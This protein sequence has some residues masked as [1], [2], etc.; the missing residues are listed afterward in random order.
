V[1]QLGGG[2][3]DHRPRRPTG[4]Q[5]QAEPTAGGGE[6]PGAGPFGQQV[7]EPGVL[8]GDVVDVPGDPAVGQVPAARPQAAAGDGEVHLVGSRGVERRGASLEGTGRQCPDPHV[9]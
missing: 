6:E 5:G 2:Q 3:L 8:L 7:V 9:R 4:V 1:R